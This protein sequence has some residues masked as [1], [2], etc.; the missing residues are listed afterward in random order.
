MEGVKGGVFAFECGLGVFAGAG[1][2]EVV[3][4]RA[5]GR[6]GDFGGGGEA[7]SAVGS[8]LGG[9]GVEGEGFGDGR[10]ELHCGR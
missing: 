3:F 2:E 10:V 5:V 8:D 6:A 9:C 7:G 1:L 4:L